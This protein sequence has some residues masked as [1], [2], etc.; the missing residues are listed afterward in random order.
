MAE[1]DIV[2]DLLELGLIVLCFDVLH[3]IVCSLEWSSKSLS[4]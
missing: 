3:V 4:R 1:K 2:I